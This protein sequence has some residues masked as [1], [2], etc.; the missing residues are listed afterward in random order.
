MK[1]TFT[2]FRKELIDTLRDR[3][4][5]FAMILFPLILMPAIF[6]ISASFSS[7]QVVDAQEKKLRVALT[8]N[9]NGAELVKRLKRRKDMT[10][11]ES[12]SPDEYRDL[13][14]ADSIDL[15]IIVQE[16]FDSKITSGQTGGLELFFNSTENNIISTRLQKT[17]DGLQDDIIAQR[18]QALGS[19]ASIINPIQLNKQDVYS[20]EESVGKAI[21][22]FLPYLFVLFCLMGA[23][24]PAIDLFTGEKER[25][26]LE[27]ILTVPASRFEILL[28]KMGVV[29]LG[30][31][32]S[33]VLTIVGMYAAVKLSP[34]IPD[35][36]VNVISNVLDPKSIGMIVLLLVPL[37]VFFA[38]LLIPASIYAK[39]FKE[40]QSTI[41]PALILVIIPLAIGMMPGIK[42]TFLTALI[43]VLN[44]AL[45]SK[46]IVA[47]TIDYGLLAVVFISLI[48]LAGLGIALCVRWFG[49]EGNVLRT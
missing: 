13:I 3:R 20:N 46:E 1:N 47:G 22:G 29:V 25:G 11:Y 6:S 38:G 31:V 12:I 26:T 4:T 18:L 28:G 15:A 16:D 10:L 17:I 36:F 32:M 42:L 24:Y 19:D 14:R 9:D 30:G 37:T 23:M 35:V 41:Q 8:S 45:A 33:G 44:V 49:Q 39:S 21:G 2:I 5:L 40:A 7:G 48:A 27:T 34:D 43:P